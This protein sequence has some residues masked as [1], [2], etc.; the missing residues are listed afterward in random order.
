MSTIPITLNGRTV[1]AEA[2]DTI[3]TAARKAGVAIPGLC[4]S[5]HLAPF[6]SCRLCVCEIDGESGTPASC[7]TPVRPNM[8]VRTESE[9]LRRHRHNIIEL[10]LSEQPGNESSGPLREL[11]LAYGV[12]KVRYP[13][14]AHQKRADIRD[15]SNPFFTFSNAACISCARCVRAC[16]EIQ[17]TRALTMTGR[18]VAARPVAGSG[19][20]TGVA[21]A[22]ATSNCVSC[23]AC[24]KECPT[25]A[26]TEKTVLAQGRRR[27]SCG[28]PAPIA[29]SGARSMP[30][31]GMAT[32]CRWCRPTM[33]RRISAMPA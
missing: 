15:D 12:N 5:S 24:V 10:Y 1:Q 32:S 16:D 22:F 28:P 7:T 29:A 27:R 2:G 30:A 21:A 4:A 31:C 8:V 17:G 6:G 23:G 13:D 18:G 11:A 20:F 26:L 9:P 3:Y 33:G 19:A 14:G 25:G